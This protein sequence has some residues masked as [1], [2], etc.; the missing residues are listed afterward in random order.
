M[1]IA[2]I[3]FDGAG[4]ARSALPPSSI[5]APYLTALQSDAM[6]RRERPSVETAAKLMLAEIDIKLAI[7]RV[8]EADMPA[9]Q[10]G[11]ILAFLN[12]AQSNVG[13]AQASLAVRS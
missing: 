2:P 9:D 13:E 12:M 3:G 4:Q 5:S 8:L 7:D 1:D 6:L 11:M 10:R